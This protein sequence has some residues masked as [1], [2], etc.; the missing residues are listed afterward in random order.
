[1]HWRI[2]CHLSCVDTKPCTHFK[3]KQYCFILYVGHTLVY[4]GEPLQ[5]LKHPWRHP[6]TALC[7]PCLG[8]ATSKQERGPFI[9]DK[10]PLHPKQRTQQGA[11]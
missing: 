7:I 2:A 11:L 10:V 3:M 5:A 6:L 8:K 9:P 1:M 4:E